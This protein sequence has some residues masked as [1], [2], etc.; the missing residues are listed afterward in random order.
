MKIMTIHTKTTVT[1]NP[2]N[3]TKNKTAFAHRRLYK[4]ERQRDDAG[5]PRQG[6]GTGTS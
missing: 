1:P 2:V 6:G 3:P 5:R 4:E